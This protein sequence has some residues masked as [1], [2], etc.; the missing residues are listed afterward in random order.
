M[1]K[2]DLNDLSLAELKKLG[3]D[4][5]KAIDTFDA[6]QKQTVMSALEVKAK[7]FGMTLSDLFSDAVGAVGIRF[8]G[9]PKTRAKPAPKYANP[10]DPSATWTGRGRKPRW[11]S[12]ALAAGKSPESMA[13]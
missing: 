3:K 12:E 7:E 4:I 13:V 8:K 2:Y 11:F 10:A 5:A 6:R 1:A 9:V